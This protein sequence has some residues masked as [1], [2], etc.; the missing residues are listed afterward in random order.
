MNVSRE[1]FSGFE[2]LNKP[3]FVSDSAIL[4]TAARINRA[5]KSIVTSYSPAFLI[6][7]P[8]RDVQ[9]AGLNSKHPLLLTKNIPIAFK[10]ML[11]NS[12]RWQQ[13]RAYG[14]WSSTVFDANG[15][16]GEI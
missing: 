16:D 7:N 13:Y 6:R 5:F 10:E 14:G 8:I 3:A 15:F 9:D 2:G 1:I 11:K 12:E 4:N